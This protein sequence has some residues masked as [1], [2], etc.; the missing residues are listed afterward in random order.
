[1]HA[2][3]RA[4]PVCVRQARCAPP[5]S[6]YHTKPAKATAAQP[7]DCLP[8]TTGTVIATAVDT[9][10]PGGLGAGL[11]K[12]ARMSSCTHVSALLSDRQAALTYCSQS[13]VELLVACSRTPAQQHQE[14]S[15]CQRKP[16]MGPSAGLKSQ[17]AVYPIT[18]CP[19]VCVWTC[20]QLPAQAAARSICTSPQ[21]PTPALKQKRQHVT[22]FALHVVWCSVQ[23]QH[24]NGMLL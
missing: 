8:T 22:A 2:A 5:L 4:R 18:L 21:V 19:I 12:V 7:S 1:M 16:G 24:H 9:A 11:P 15:C 10:M 13:R 23:G 17:A 14:S 20:D 3:A 6:A